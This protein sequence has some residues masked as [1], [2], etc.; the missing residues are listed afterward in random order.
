MKTLEKSLATFNSYNV[1]HST[2]GACEHV[3]ITYQGE[4]STVQKFRHQLHPLPDGIKAIEAASN[5]KR[6]LKTL[7]Q[8]SL[9][10]IFEAIKANKLPSHKPHYAQNDG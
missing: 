9:K 2:T 5:L 1:S 3:S 4:H 7:P 8:E 10:A 6:A